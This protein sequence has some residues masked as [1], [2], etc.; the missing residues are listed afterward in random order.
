MNE[1]TCG[2]A[3]GVRFVPSAHIMAHNCYSLTLVLEHLRVFFWPLLG[4]QAKNGART[5]IRQSGHKNTNESFKKNECPEDERMNER[6]N[7]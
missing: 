7:E 1:R 4:Q 2:S 6:T 5:Y 3:E